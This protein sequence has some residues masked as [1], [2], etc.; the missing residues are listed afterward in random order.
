MTLL[1]DGG[2]NSS[3]FIRDTFDEIDDAG[4]IIDT[5]A[6]SDAA[7]PQLEALSNMTSGIPAFCPDSGSGSCVTQAFQ[8]TITQRPD[9]GT[10]DVPVQV[11]FSYTLTLY[12]GINLTLLS[13]PLSLPISI[14]G[15]S[16]I[17]AQR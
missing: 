2:E 10:E 17:L 5:I 14:K 3:P 1:S 16:R 8:S 13:L 4:V 15:E 12:S 11:S 9:L 7:D 6:I